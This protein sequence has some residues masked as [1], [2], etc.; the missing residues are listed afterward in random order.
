M[1]YE[2]EQ[3]RL[4]RDDQHHW[5]TLEIT[6]TRNSVGRR[7]KLSNEVTNLVYMSICLCLS[8][9]SQKS[10][11]PPQKN[12]SMKIVEVLSI[13]GEGVDGGEKMGGVEATEELRVLVLD[14]LS[15][16]DGHLQFPEVFLGQAREGSPTDAVFCKEFNEICVS[17]IV[18]ET[19]RWG[20][21]GF[22]RTRGIDSCE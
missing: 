12:L 18:L 11:N 6:R 19:Y 13:P 1:P 9:S 17:A 7:R 20:S 10:V 14:V 2:R 16:C 15:F 21:R 3:G 5:P 8:Q 4:D 22:P